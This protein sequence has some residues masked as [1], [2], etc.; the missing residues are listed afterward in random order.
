MARKRREPEKAPNAERWLLTYADLITLLLIFFIVMYTMSNVNAEKFKQV[1]S[2]LTAAF[3]VFRGTNYLVGESPGPSF[4]PD[5][6]SGINLPNGVEKTPEEISFDEIEEKIKG[7]A[8]EKGLEGSISVIREERGI[9]VDLKEAALFDVGSDVL[10]PEAI[11]NVVEVGKII[12]TSCPN[13]HVRIEGHTDDTP[14]NTL[15]F[16]SNWELSAARANSVR[17]ILQEQVGMNPK[18]L[19]IIGYGEYRPIVPNDTPENKSKN[20]RVVIAILKS[21]FNLLEPGNIQQLAGFVPLP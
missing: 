11:A 16:P 4:I 6:L 12:F 15:R 9:A 7:L 19:S 10:G 1:A 2:S 18:N 13:N 14:I 21:E 5:G 8:A 20:R 17:I 3:S